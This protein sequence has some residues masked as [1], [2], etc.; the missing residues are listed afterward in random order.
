MATMETLGTVEILERL[1]ACPT[2][3]RDP[4]LPLID[5]VR[6]FLADHGVD[7]ALVHGRHGTQVESVREHRARRQKA[8]SCCPGHTDV[9]PDRRAGLEQRSVQARRRG[10]RDSMRAARAT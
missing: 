8:G 6:N 7:F 9:V 10:D 5:W 4:N 1:V 3:S 2:V